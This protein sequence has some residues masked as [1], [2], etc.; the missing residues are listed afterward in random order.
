MGHPKYPVPDPECPRC[1]EPVAYRER[2]KCRDCGRWCHGGCSTGGYG[3]SRCLKCTGIG[4]VVDDIAEKLELSE[5]QKVS[6]RVIVAALE[7]GTDAERVAEASGVPLD[8]VREKAARLADS[9]VWMPDGKMHVSLDDP[10]TSGVEFLLLVM[11]ADGEVVRRKTPA[12][13]KP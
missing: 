2:K 4:P 9:G 11:C 10:E 7:E 5:E 3:N 13:E 12:A 6:A 8:V 1:G